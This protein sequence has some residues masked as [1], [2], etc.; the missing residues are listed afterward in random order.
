MCL[1]KSKAFRFILRN[2]LRYEE[3]KKLIYKKETTICL[4]LSLHRLVQRVQ[5]L[6]YSPQTTTTT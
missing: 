6:L 1:F 4:E 5:L 3:I 2:E